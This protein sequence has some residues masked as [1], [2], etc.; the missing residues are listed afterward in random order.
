MRGRPPTPRAIAA[1]V[2]TEMLLAEAL[3]VEEIGERL[4]DLK[5]VGAVL[6]LSGK[7]LDEMRRSQAEMML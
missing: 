3:T 7:G 1:P 4:A 5:P 2:I 6:L